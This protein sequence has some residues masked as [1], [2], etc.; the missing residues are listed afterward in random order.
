MQ[1]DEVTSTTSEATVAE[2][3]AVSDTEGTGGIHAL[4]FNEVLEHNGKH[5]FVGDK[6]E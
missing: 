6:M 3:G 4:I 5:E 1:W 2:G